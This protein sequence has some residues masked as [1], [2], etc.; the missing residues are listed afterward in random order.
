MDRKQEHRQAEVVSPLGPDV[1][2]FYHMAA[3]EGIS[4]MYSYDLTVFSEDEDIA[5]DDLIGQHTHVELELPHGETRYFC[6]H[7][8]EF[9]FLG[10]QGPLAKYKVQL[11]PW[12]WF[13]TRAIN[14]RIFQK[15][16]VLDIIRKVCAEHGFTDIRFALEEGAYSTR[17]Y[18]VQ[19]RETDFAFLSRLM[20]EE[21]IYYFFEH[22]SGKHVLVLADS[23]SAHDPFGN[24]EIVP[25]FPPDQHDRR[26]RDHID[27]WQVRRCVRSGAV[28]LRDYNF[29][30]PS[31][32]LEVKSQM[33]RG[34]QNAEFEQY[35][36]PGDYEEPNAGQRNARLM[37]EAEQADIEI[38]RGSGN[39][40]G[41]LPGFVFE[42]E[43]YPRA[44]QNKEYLILSV[45]HDMMNDEYDSKSE[46][47]D[48]SFNY[49]CSF[50]AIPSS[51]QFR[52]PRRTPRPIVHGPQT[53]VVVGEQ[54]EEIWTDAHGRVKVLFHWDRL[55]RGE[56]GKG[57]ENSSCW[58]RVSQGWAGKKWGMQFI[59][60]IGHEVVVEF[61]EGDPDRPLVTGSVYNADNKPPYDLPDKATQSG[62][63][64]RSSK[65]G[66]RTDFNEIRFE[67]KK[68][69]EK[70]Y[71][72]AEKDMAIFVENNQ[73]V[74]V[75]QNKGVQVGKNLCEV[76]G[77]NYG[78]SV[79]D[80]HE[81]VVGTRRATTVALPD[82]VR[83]QVIY[84]DGEHWTLSQINDFGH[85]VMKSEAEEMLHVEGSRYVYVKD[86]DTLKIDDNYLIEVENHW[87]HKSATILIEANNL[88]EI[89][90]KTA[91]IEITAGDSIRVSAPKGFHLVDTEFNS[92][93][94][95]NYEISKI[96]EKLEKSVYTHKWHSMG[97]TFFKLDT[98]Q[99]AIGHTSVKV[100]MPGI[101]IKTGYLFKKDGT[102]LK[103]L[104]GK[105]EFEFPLFKLIG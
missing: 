41:L 49:S 48:A 105:F 23:V 39:A 2:L 26:E 61:L 102:K 101:E 30:T 68:G 51:E 56:D 46:S 27:H 80:Q 91:N 16:S 65:N 22:E 25:Y 73:S 45:T 33:P 21:G 3:N 76:I 13:L 62:I 58:I 53:G 66:S 79:A 93:S 57:D 85:Q 82:P 32:N 35:D 31:A 71:M 52:P 81:L 60:R 37:L 63:K 69:E 86:N 78:L 40:R 92:L 24:Y 15:E 95:I 70:F 1:L 96:K 6:G 98:T 28:A 54:G 43:N 5:F 4:Q 103:L 9:S 12:I 90:S 29:E 84:P 99:F 38:L 75:N 94:V 74:A 89:Q 83:P 77:E 104:N 55:G 7:V 14:C 50:V 18:C 11:R 34:H 72:H 87:T 97:N 19:Y 88:F 100:E 20:E 10:Y 36:Y 67:D 59:P 44:D 8:T 42:L 47:R 64:T 17:E